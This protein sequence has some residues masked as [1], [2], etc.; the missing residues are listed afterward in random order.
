MHTIAKSVHH[1]FYAKTER[2]LVETN[3]SKRSWVKLQLGVETVLGAAPQ[4]AFA[5]LGNACTSSLAAGLVS[6]AISLAEGLP[7]TTLNSGAEGALAAESVTV[8]VVIS[9]YFPFKYG[10]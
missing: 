1:R 8:D 5:V 6:A 7:L 9:F 4:V 3:I 2:I 10:L